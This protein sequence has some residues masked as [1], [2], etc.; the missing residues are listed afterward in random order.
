MACGVMDWIGIIFSLV[1]FTRV[2]LIFGARCQ[3]SFLLRTRGEE[4]FLFFA[5]AAGLLAFGL[6][7]ASAAWLRA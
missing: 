7:S 1:V 4:V 2:Q 6:L 3:N 5:T